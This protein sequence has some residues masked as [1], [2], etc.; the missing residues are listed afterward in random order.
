MVKRFLFLFFLSFCSYSFSALDNSYLVENIKVSFVEKDATIAR[1]V[2]IDYAEVFALRNVFSS[3]GIDTSNTFY[4]KKNEIPQAIKLMQIKNERITKNSYSATLN[5]EFNPEYLH[6]LLSK[7]KITRY[8]PKF[9]SYLIIPYYNDGKNTILAKNNPIL[10]SF[11]GKVKYTNNILLIKED[12]FTTINLKKVVKSNLNWD[13]YKPLMDYYNINN[14]VFLFSKNNPKD[15]SKITTELILLEEQGEVDKKTYN[16]SINN[17]T[18][19]ILDYI[20]DINK[21]LEEKEE[22]T[23]VDMQEGY[24]RL[25]IDINSINDYVEIEKKLNYN[26]T[27]Q[28]KELRR[29]TKKNI[30][31]HVKFINN[32]K[33]MFIKSLMN[34]RFTVTEKGDGIHAFI[35]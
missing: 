11:S 22:D 13:D 10:I 30:V 14:L 27:I 35:Q 5:I 6:F 7:Y 28:A 25:Y 31:Y 3:L 23:E 9:N 12:E 34:N 21:E 19:D 1:E 29:L 20:S 32:N 26:D 18:T 4:I 17:T 24:V 33:K 16:N 8:S 2:A 15:K